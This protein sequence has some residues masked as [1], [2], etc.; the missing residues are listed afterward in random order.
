MEEQE[1]GMTVEK[2]HLAETQ[3]LI[4]QEMEKLF[5]ELGLMK[6]EI[7]DYSKFLTE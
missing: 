7:V 1:K 4:Q 3:R 2:E 5:K 6:Q